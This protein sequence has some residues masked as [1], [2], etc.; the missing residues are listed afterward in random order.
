[1]MSKQLTELYKSIALDQIRQ[2]FYEAK[3]GW[4]SRPAPHTIS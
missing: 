4:Y 2:T 1:M 3:S